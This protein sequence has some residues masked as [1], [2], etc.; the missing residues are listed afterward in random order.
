METTIW[1]SGV[2]SYKKHTFEF[3]PDRA[4]YTTEILDV[5]LSYF[6]NA[7]EAII[8]SLDNSKK[9][10]EVLYSGGLD[11]ECILYAC[12]KYDIPVEPITLRLLV[13]NAPINIHD[14]YYSEKFCSQHRLNQKIVDFHIDRFYDNGDH[15]PYLKPYRARLINTASI[16]WLLERCSR[17]PVIGGDYMWPQVSRNVYSPWRSDY[18]CFDHFMKE[19]GIDGVGNMLS[20]SPET[21]MFFIKEH[22]RSYDSTTIFK[23]NIVNNLGFS[24]EHRHSSYGWE[25]FDLKKVNDD[26]TE[27]FG[28]THNSIIWNE[29]FGKLIGAGPGKNDKFK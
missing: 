4:T 7:Q 25:R 14:L 28:H 10:I 29:E 16:M 12:M 5:D 9:P 6:D 21:N 15:I 22:I 24:L 19:K 11:S 3:Y 27:I 18:G 20:H 2:N 17:F 26:L 13:K 1:Y 8:A 23:N